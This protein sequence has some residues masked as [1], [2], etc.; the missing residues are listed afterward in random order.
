MNKKILVVD[1]DKELVDF[2]KDYLEKDGYSV[3][4]TYDGKEAL[5]LFR[6]REFDLIV[7]DLMLPEMDGYKV[8]KRMRRDSDVP[9]VMLTAKT[10]DEEKIKGLDLG[11]DDYVTKPFNPGELLA[12]IRAS[13]RRVEENGQPKE[14]TYGDLTV[15]FSRKEVLLDNEPVDITP[16]EFKILAALVKEPDKVFSRTQ[17]IHA[18]LGYGYESFERTIDVHIKH[19]RDKIEPDPQNPSYI[20]TVFG[21]GYK[22]DSRGKGGGGEE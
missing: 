16:T 6:K 11:A 5:Q 3:T 10:A 8:C 4:G 18:A 19:L 22:F 21:M 17:L 1:D 9:I 14:V 7:L 13:L 20:K 15:N 2:L 12:R